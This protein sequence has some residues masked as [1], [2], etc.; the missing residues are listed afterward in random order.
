M[1]VTLRVDNTTLSDYLHY[2]YPQEADGLKVSSDN[3]LG[4]L[5]IAHCREAPAPMFPIEGECVVTL[6]LP[7]CRATQTLENKFLYYTAGDMAQ[8][9]MALR[10]CFDL[11]LATYYRKGEAV[12]FSK[13]DIVEGFI[14]SRK[15]LSK[16][17]F[18]A[19]HKRVYRRQQEIMGQLSRK[20]QR[21]LYY[22]EECMDDSGLKK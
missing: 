3:I 14:F 16:D 2:L 22:L 4:K 12:G 8:L 17:N 1:T 6:I 9:N 5:L 18:D 10:A 7:K 20:L 15:L 21:K 13:K 11:D 19:I